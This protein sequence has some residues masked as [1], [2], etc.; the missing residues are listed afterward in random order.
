MARK[1][2]LTEVTF[3]LRMLDK[4]EPGMGIS[5]REYFRQETTS[6]KCPQWGITLSDSR[7]RKTSVAGKRSP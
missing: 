6:V 4:K 5:G 3:E 2:L 7:D 1:S